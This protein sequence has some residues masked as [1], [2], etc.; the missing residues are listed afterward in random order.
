MFLVLEIMTNLLYSFTNSTFLMVF[1]ETYLKIFS[2]Y[3]HME[4][5]LGGRGG[6]AIVSKEDYKILSS[7]NWSK[8]TQGYVVGK[9][10]GRSTRMHLFIMKK[11]K[12]H[13]IDHINGVRHDNRRE[14]LRY[15]PANKN[16]QNRHVV[17]VN[18]TSKYRGISK[19]KSGRYR[20][21][22]RVDNKRHYL[23]LFDKEIDAITAWDMFIVHNKLD[24]IELN[25]PEKREEYLTK[26]YIPYT[27]K[28]SPREY[29]GVY[30]H[31]N[32]YRA[33]IGVNNRSLHLGSFKDKLDAARAYDSYIIK[34]NILGKQLNFPEEHPEY[35]LT[36]IVRT[37]YEDVDEST[38][39]LMIGSDNTKVVTIDREDYDKIKYF[40]CSFINDYISICIDNKEVRISRFFLNITDPDVFVDHIDNNTLNNTK[41]NLRLSDSKKN[42]QNRKKAEN[43]TSKY[44]GVNHR[45]EDNLWSGEVINDHNKVFRKAYREEILAARARDLYIIDHL[46]DTHYKLNFKWTEADKANWRKK[47]AEIDSNPYKRS[48][49]YGKEHT[50]AEKSNPD[51]K[52]KYHGVSRNRTLWDARVCKDRK[53]VF[54]KSFKSEEMA[55]RAR[56]LYILKSIKNY[57]FKLNFEWSADDIEMWSKKLGKL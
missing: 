56:D 43:T 29:T 21:T 24:H 53:I 2:I 32:R 5:T 13:V 42:P 28:E 37:E 15:L 47:L 48:S 16:P 51:A 6:T 46:P 54:R 22:I 40:K 34:N 14:N 7:F 45:K 23:G 17:K 4:I 50:V 3:I 35:C 8:D 11:K 30:K 25:F 19:M 18:N 10:N 31:K 20:A 33:E 12:H 41:K 55:A 44:I 36:K 52:S 9:V 49:H 57:S 1:C 38:I 39:R 27:I 26:E